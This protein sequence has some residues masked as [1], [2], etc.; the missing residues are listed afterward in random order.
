MEEYA[1]VFHSFSFADSHA[2][3]FHC[4][5][6][7]QA[8]LFYQF[9]QDGRILELADLEVNEISLVGCRSVFDHLDH[10]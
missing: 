1:E 3:N 9:L 4:L 5:T 10:C 8:Y 7:S 6:I 2:V